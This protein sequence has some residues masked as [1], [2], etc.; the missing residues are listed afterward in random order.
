MG[1]HRT[2]RKESVFPRTRVP[3]GTLGGNPSKS[4]LRAF[5]RSVARP[6][7]WQVDVWRAW[8][9]VLIT[10]ILR[11]QTFDPLSCEHLE[12]SLAER[13]RWAPQLSCAS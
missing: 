4:G 13:G 12:V 7:T 1:L 3:R 6:L 2:R 9:V 11:D 8:A 5:R 10:P